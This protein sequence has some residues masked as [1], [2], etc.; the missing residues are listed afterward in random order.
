MRGS[1]AASRQMNYETGGCCVG[2]RQAHHYVPQMNLGRFSPE[3]GRDNPLLWTLECSTGRV[4]KSSV[5]VGRLVTLY[6]QLNADP[7]TIG[8]VVV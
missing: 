2:S 7:L 1:V 3:P 5:N 6:R 8:F 4:R